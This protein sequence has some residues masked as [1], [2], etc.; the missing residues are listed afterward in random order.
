MAQSAIVK[1]ERLASAFELRL[2]DVVEDVARV[3]TWHEPGDE[4]V[5]WLSKQHGWR[6]EMAVSYLT[7]VKR[8]VLALD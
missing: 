2:D 6:A 5:A 3:K 1:L 4:L 7:T 8:F